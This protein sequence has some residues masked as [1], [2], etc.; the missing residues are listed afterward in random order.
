M[1]TAGS[2]LQAQGDGTADVSPKPSLLRNS[3]SFGYT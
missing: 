3:G 1:A 2:V